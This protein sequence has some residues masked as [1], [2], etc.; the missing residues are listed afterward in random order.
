M[1]SIS[2]GLPTRLNAPATAARILVGQRI[3]EDDPSNYAVESWPDAIWLMF[4]LEYEVDRNC[5]QDTRTEPGELLTPELWPRDA[6]E[7]MKRGLQGRRKDEPGLSSFAVSALL[8]Q[9]PV[10][11]GGGIIPV[12]DWMVWPEFPPPVGDVRRDKKGEII[13][14]LPELLVDD[15]GRARILRLT[16][17]IASATPPITMLWLCGEF[18]A[19]AARM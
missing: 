12:N 8:Q 1:R 3:C 7:R 5:P 15:L 4:P 14:Q 11:R 10:P 17:P 16:P 19:A 9:S 2:E 13:L 18:L 6:V